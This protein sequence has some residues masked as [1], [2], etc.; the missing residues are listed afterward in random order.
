MD[1]YHLEHPD[2][3]TPDDATEDEA[4][5]AQTGDQHERAVLQEFRSSATSVVEIPRTNF[6]VARTETRAAM[7]A[8]VP[9]I[10]QAALQR[11]PFSG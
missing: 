6:G 7:A 5:I 3:V 9:V 10:Y 2:A 8:K 1:R 11:E 4:L